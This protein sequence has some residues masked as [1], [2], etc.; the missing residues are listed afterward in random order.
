LAKE[1]FLCAIN[2]ILSGNCSEDCKFCTQSIKYGAKIE[3]YRFKDSSQIIQEAEVALKNGA[4]GYCLVT[5]GRGLDDK[6]T[7]KIA[8]IAYSLKEKFPKLNL[9][10]CNGT[11]SKE[12][13]K[14]LKRNGID[15]YNHN[16]E[17]SKEYYSKICTTHTW[18]ERYETALNIKEVG[19]NLCCGGIFGMGES[20]DDRDSLI[21]SIVS[22]KPESVPINFYIPNSVLPIKSRNINYDEALD[23]IKKLRELLLDAKIMVAGGRELIF[24]SVDKE[25]QMYEAG[26]NSIVIG[27]YLTT[28]GAK[29]KSDL[30]HLRALGLKIAKGCDA[31]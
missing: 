2:N 30:E 31:K 14:I 25:L 5:A 19:L 11:A 10:A 26:T 17:S 27:N 6:T 8:K 21:E 16:L 9:I 20:K 15:S 23:I 4:I 24:N 3:R 13:L 18:Q 1:I 29:P 12:Q 28:K 7:Q 22:L